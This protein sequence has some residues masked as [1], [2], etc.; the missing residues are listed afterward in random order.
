MFVF[1]YHAVG[2]G[3]LIRIQNQVYSAPVKLAKENLFNGRK[4]YGQG[5]NLKS[6]ECAALCIYF[7]VEPVFL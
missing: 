2:S 6:L 3:S 5:G 7:A 4:G 1:I